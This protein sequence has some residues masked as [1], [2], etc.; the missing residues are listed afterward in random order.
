[1]NIQMDGNADELRLQPHDEHDRRLIRAITCVA[2]DGGTITA[3]PNG[4]CEVTRT[5]W[6]GRGM[7]VEDP[8]APTTWR[9]RLTS[10]VWLNAFI[11]GLFR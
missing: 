9:K 1:M 4:D 2:L 5:T 7:R 11:T 3:A 8:V 10:G 6:P